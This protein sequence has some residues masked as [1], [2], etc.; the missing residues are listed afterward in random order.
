MKKTLPLLL[1]FFI[2][3]VALVQAQ[4]DEEYVFIVGK[5]VDSAGRPV[6]GVRILYNQTD[7]M[8]W[9][10][11]AKSLVV[12]NQGQIRLSFPSSL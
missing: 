1:L 4:A 10:T 11:V 6:E 5:L 12:S 8:K 9:K 7:K 3:N 2:A